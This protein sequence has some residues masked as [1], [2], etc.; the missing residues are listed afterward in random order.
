[1]SKPMRFTDGEK[2]F[3]DANDGCSLATVYPDKRPHIVPVNFLLIDGLFYVASDY[4][5]R[6]L[7]N[8][9][10]NNKV[11]LL[12]ATFNPNRAVIIEGE[13]SLLEHGPAFKHVYE[14][15]YKRFSWVRNDPWS[16]GEAPF[17]VVKPVKKIRW[18]L[19]ST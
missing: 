12:V 1:M 2:R 7:K 3:L 17:I 11:A 19:K 16:E 13:A 4:N 9:Q 15:F 18:G 10:L 5:T 14:M 6:K 8:I